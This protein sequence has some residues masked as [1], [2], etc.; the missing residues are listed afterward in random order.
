VTE[1]AEAGQVV[2]AEP[3][4]AEIAAGIAE[5][6]RLRFI[7]Y[8]GTALLLAMIVVIG[9][10]SVPY[11]KLSP[12]PM[13]NTIG[14][15]GGVDL[16]TIK[17][18]QTYP[19]NG[20]LDL[21]TV[22]ERGGPYGGLTLPE[23]IV[24][25]LDPDQRVVPVEVLYPPGTTAD[26]ARSENAAEFTSSQSAATA[27][28]LRYLKIPVTS[29]VSVVEVVANGPANGVLQAGDIVTGV[30]GK[31]V[32]KPSEVPA[33]IRARKPGTEVTFSIT[34]GGKPMEVKIKIAASPK[35]PNQGF[36]GVQLGTDYSGPFPIIFGLE[37]VGGPSAGMM[38]TLGIIDKLTPG[39]I[40]GGKLVAGTGTIDA[41]GKV[42]P[43][44][45]IEQK[46]AAARN[47]GSQIFLA[48]Q[49]N[50]DDVAKLDLKGLNV[51][52]V[53][54]IEDAVNVLT[55]WNQGSPDLPRCQP[56]P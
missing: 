48:P 20:Q 50:C 19:T 33:L 46:L 53:A 26:E 39:D 32:T 56:T 29:Q 37:D 14:S 21:V 44:G 2:T 43:I 28:A 5:Y 34:R 54:T 55:K 22:N 11:V 16:V 30:D 52:K 40:N 23:A 4:T 17:D 9:F 15:S 24:G 1:P 6:R 42:G 41:D 51:A 47:H 25:W 3:P 38:F 8:C 27:A 7:S 36:I 49:A 45:G 18:H 35:N 31:A 10:V 13:Y 12:G